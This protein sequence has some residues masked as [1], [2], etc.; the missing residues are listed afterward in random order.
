MNLN[1]FMGHSNVYI[2]HDSSTQVSAERRRPRRPGFS[3]SLLPSLEFHFVSQMF[4]DQPR[5]PWTKNRTSAMTL[6][7][8]NRTSAITLRTGTRASKS[9]DGKDVDVLRSPGSTMKPFLL[10][11]YLLVLTKSF[12]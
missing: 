9:Q 12:S 7:T 2:L 11:I 4:A 3:N 10:E 1:F 8:K 5:R 6:G